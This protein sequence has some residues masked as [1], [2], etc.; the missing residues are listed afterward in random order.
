MS[1]DGIVKLADFGASKKVEAF[2]TD[3]DKMMEELTMRGTPYFMAPEVFEEKYGPRAD[4]WSVGGLIYQMATANPPWK[5]MG[6]NNPISLF[7]HLKSSNDVPQLPQ[8]KGDSLDGG[9]RHFYRLLSNVLTRCFQRDPAKR[10]SAS[11][12]LLDDLFDNTSSVSWATSQHNTQKSPKKANS[13]ESRLNIPSPNRAGL[14]SN[15]LA[16]IDS[17]LADSLSYSLSIPTPLTNL[18][19]NLTNNSNGAEVDT[20]DWPQ[21]A[22]NSVNSGKNPF[23]KDTRM[24]KLKSNQNVNGRSAVIDSS[25][26]PQWAKNSGE[27]AC[28]PSFKCKHNPFGRN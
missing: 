14:K 17:S 5:D 9:D 3:P 7:F 22:K 21:W 12:L 13:A 28:N 6:F 27:S 20:S 23:A 18:N 16:A 15:T 10:P 19:A 4:I 11:A 26:W 2:G 1:N 25:E 24:Q 8:L